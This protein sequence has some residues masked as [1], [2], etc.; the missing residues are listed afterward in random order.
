[1]KD[2]ITE[3]IE[4]FGEDVSAGAKMPAS[5]TLFEVDDT[6]TSP[7][8]KKEKADMFHHIVAELLFVSKRA[9][10]DI[11]LA[12]AFLCTRISCWLFLRIGTHSL[13]TTIGTIMLKSFIARAIASEKKMIPTWGARRKTNENVTKSH[14]YLLSSGATSSWQLKLV[15]MAHS[16]S[17][18]QVHEE[19]REKMIMD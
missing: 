13:T 2:Y 9:R 12:V 10:I 17:N 6:D 14:S 5:S 8:L 11:Q 15:A 7:K 1:M 3:C 18:R 16:A 19:T 4:S